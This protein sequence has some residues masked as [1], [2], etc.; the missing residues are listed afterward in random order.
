MCPNLIGPK[1]QNEESPHCHVAVTFHHFLDAWGKNTVWL[2][3]LASSSRSVACRRSSPSESGSMIA[4]SGMS[5]ILQ[6]LAYM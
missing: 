1:L 4:I 2:L 6:L 3:L 5:T